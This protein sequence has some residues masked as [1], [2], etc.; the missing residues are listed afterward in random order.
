MSFPDTARNEMGRRILA[1]LLSY[2]A[3]LG[4]DYTLNR[5]VPKEGMEWLGDV[6][7]QLLRQLEEEAGTKGRRKPRS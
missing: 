3:G 1:A 7:L 5:Y 2:H 6:G 4:L